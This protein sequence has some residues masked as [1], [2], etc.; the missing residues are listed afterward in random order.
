MFLSK[1][2]KD[3]KNRKR[4]NKKLNRIGGGVDDIINEVCPHIF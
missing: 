1:R 4:S 2:T 3:L